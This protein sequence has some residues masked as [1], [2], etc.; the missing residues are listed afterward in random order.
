MKDNSEISIIVFGDICPVSDTLNGFISQN[1]EKII[2]KEILNL[3]AKSDITIG[4]LECSLTDNPKPIYKTGPVL[5]APTITAK[6]LVSAGFKAFSIAN[7]HIR[8]CGTSGFEDT[9]RACNDNNLIVF[10]GGFS[11]STAKEP[12]V[13]ECKGK[14][15]AFLSY[16]ESE[17]NFLTE[18]RPGAA[19]LDI[20]EDFEAI[21][22]IK[23]EVDL[24][25]ILYHGGIEYHPYPSPLLQKKCRKMAES[26]ADYIICQHS[27]CI[28]T[29]EN[30]KNSYILYGQG[31][32]LFGYRKGNPTW[33]N[34][35]LLRISLTDN[36]KSIEIIPCET[37]SNSVFT[38][39]PKAKANTIKGDFDK[40]SSHIDDKNFIKKEWSKFCKKSESLNLPLLLGW[41][42]YLIFINRKLNGALVK[43]LFGR[44]KKNITHNLIRC[45]AHNEVINT[46][47]SQYDYE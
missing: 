32:C 21:S 22:R 2:S 19:T 13:F 9:L 47:L 43:Y 36:H 5:Y 7:N 25:I 1:P 38:L 33:N 3:I 34:G 46:I 4:N 16:S 27:H 11:E 35:L 29:F 17:Y 12:F 30:Y 14:K 41:N 20:Y 28:G 40:M 44:H 24:L 45:E 39:I 37:D 10:G 42:R 18:E 6:T 23:K 15:I 26:G 8:D 31:N